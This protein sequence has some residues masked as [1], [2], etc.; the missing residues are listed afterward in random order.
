M[1]V[2]VGKLLRAEFPA[3]PVSELSL[4]SQMVRLAWFT[5]LKLLMSM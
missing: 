1:L 4:S 5:S 3:S 2:E